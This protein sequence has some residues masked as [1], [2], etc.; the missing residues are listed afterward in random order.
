MKSTRRWWAILASVVVVG[1]VVTA[2]ALLLGRETP[3]DRNLRD[4]VER[5][6]GSRYEE[7]SMRSFQTGLV[8]ACMR[9]RGY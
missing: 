8:A 5:Y 6:G 4:C 1:L 7:A 3:H 9:G 2:G